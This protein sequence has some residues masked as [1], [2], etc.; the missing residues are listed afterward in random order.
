MANEVS[1]I[2]GVTKKEWLGIFVYTFSN[3]VK[4]EVDPHDTD[5]NLD[6]ITHFDID[7]HENRQYFFGEVGDK[8]GQTNGVDYIEELARLGYYRDNSNIEGV[9]AF[10]KTGLATDAKQDIQINLAKTSPNATVTNQI[11]VIVS[12]NILPLNGNRKQFTVYNNSNRDCYLKIGT[13]ASL[14]DNTVVI[15]KKAFYV[16]NTDSSIISVI[17]D[18]TGTGQIQITETNIL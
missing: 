6:N 4:I 9:V 15:E 16:N 1:L 5:T 3:G 2:N 10:D 7:K 8:K 17:F 13:G 18:N 12:T 11:P 14:V